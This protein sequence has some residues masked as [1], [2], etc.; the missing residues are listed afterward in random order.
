MLYCDCNYFQHCLLL[1]PQS[2]QFIVELNRAGAFRNV[3]VFSFCV[4]GLSV[5]CPRQSMQSTSSELMDT[6]QRIDLTLF[7][8]VCEIICVFLRV[9]G[10]VRMNARTAHLSQPVS[11]SVCEP[12]RLTCVYVCLF[13]FVWNTDYHSEQSV[14]A[15]WTDKHTEWASECVCWPSV[16]H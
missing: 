12:K 13:V 15:A 5:S 6:T 8:C 16:A 2:E 11:A 9:F 4:S 3:T 14:A 1:L 10:D 7:K